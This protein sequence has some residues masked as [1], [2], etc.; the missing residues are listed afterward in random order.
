MDRSYIATLSVTILLAL[1]GYLVTYGNNLRLAQRK[2]RLER[3]ERQLRDLYGPLLS[4]AEAST[5]I[6]NAFRGRY[7]PSGAFWGTREGPSEEEVA[8]WRAWMSIVFQPMNE[9]MAQLVT[10]HADLIEEAEMPI[11]LLDLYAHV[12]A[13]RPVLKAWVA[14]DHSEHTS[15]LEFP[16]RELLAYARA[17]YNRLKQEQAHLLGKRTR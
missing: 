15:L 17:H 11:V 13:Y 7:R 1:L 5:R 8:V 9:E 2:D 14:N 6:W 12:A 16:T 4:T 3:V 10:D